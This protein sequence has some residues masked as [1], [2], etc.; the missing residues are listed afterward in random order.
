V[1]LAGVVAG[2]LMVP[3]MGRIARSLIRRVLG[4]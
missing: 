3:L 1:H 4:F 2:F